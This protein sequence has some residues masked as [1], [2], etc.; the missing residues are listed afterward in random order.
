MGRRLILLFTACLA[1]QIIVGCKQTDPKEVGDAPSPPAESSA[2]THR[3]K[4]NVNPNAV[5]PQ[6]GAKAG[7]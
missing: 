3:S 1:G 6:T 5:V 2:Q 4:G 7:G